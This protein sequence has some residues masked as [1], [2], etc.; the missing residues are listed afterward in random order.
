MRRSTISLGRSRAGAELI[1]IVVFI[2]EAMMPAS[3]VFPNPGGPYKSKW[4]IGSCLSLAASMPINN[5]L[6]SCSC[7]V[8]SCRVLGLNERS[9]LLSSEDASGLV[10]LSASFASLF[11]FCG[12]LS[13]ETIVKASPLWFHLL[14]VSASLTYIITT[15][16]QKYVYE[17]VDFKSLLRPQMLFSLFFSF[18]VVLQCV[19]VH[20]N[21]SEIITKRE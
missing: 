6:F 21:I 8:Y 20:Y 2:S 5:V 16:L 13:D 7:P 3:V 1:R 9:K 15:I 18:L 17:K 19:W 4:S 10:S 12:P 11:G 14:H